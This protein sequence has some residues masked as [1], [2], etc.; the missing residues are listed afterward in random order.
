MQVQRA[1]IQSGVTSKLKSSRKSATGGPPALFRG[2]SWPSSRIRTSPLRGVP[3]GPVIVVFAFSFT[4]GTLPE[5]PKPDEISGSEDGGSEEDG[6]E[7]EDGSEED[8]S[9][10]EDGETVESDGGVEAAWDE[11]VGEEADGEAESVGNGAD[12][13]GALVEESEAEFGESG[14]A[15]SAE[16]GSAVGVEEVS[17]EPAAAVVP[18][19]AVP[20][21]E[22][23]SSEDVP[24][25]ESAEAASAVPVSPSE[26]FRNGR[27]FPSSSMSGLPEV[28]VWDSSDFFVEADA[29]E[30]GAEAVV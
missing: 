19:A 21:E 28:Q 25:A 17:V 10:G 11:S 24:D 8:G 20:S 26:T 13:A 3:S 16:A 1:S 7:G 22:F 4:G 27:A 9:E 29:S 6:S 5:T 12:E 2:G 30:V 14:D 18:S 23:P 15:G